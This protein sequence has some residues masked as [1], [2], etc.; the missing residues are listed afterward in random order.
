M[1]ATVVGGVFA[2]ECGQRMLHIL[3][4]LTD[5][6]FRELYD[7]RCRC[8]KADADA[9]YHDGLD[10]VYSWDDSVLDDDV[11]EVA[12]QCPDLHDTFQECVAQYVLDRYRNRRSEHR[13]PEFRHFLRAFLESIGKHDELVSVRWFTAR[14]PV[15]RRMACGDSARNALYSLPMHVSDVELESDVGPDDSI[16]QVAS[17]DPPPEP[18]PPETP[19]SRPRSVPLPPP[20]P[21]LPV[22]LEDPLRTMEAGTTSGR[23]RPPTAES[24]V[25]NTASRP[26]PPSEV[27]SAASRHRPPPTLPVASARSDVGS[28]ASRHRPPPAPPVTPARSEVGSTAS[29]HRPPPAVAAPESPTVDRYHTSTPSA[30]NEPDEY[31]AGVSCKTAELLMAPSGSAQEV[32]MGMPRQTSPM[33]RKQ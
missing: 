7:N 13:C 14:D 27:G 31:G 9:Y 18:A 21:Q 28:T 22:V 11:R 33:R 5:R 16:S 20:R 32:T 19:P 17:P 25:R 2:R 8:S 3:E 12:R 6:A 30:S 24:D 15:A 29:R 1:S 4:I 10:A 26:R 23:G